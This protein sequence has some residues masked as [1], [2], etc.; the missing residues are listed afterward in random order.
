MSIA[1]EIT[2]IN[3]NIADAYTALGTKGATLPQSQNS[4]NLVSTI[5][6][7]TTL[8]QYIEGEVTN[9]TGYA[10][11]VAENALRNTSSLVSVNLPYAE[12]V[13]RFGFAYCR[14]LESVR[15]DSCT[16]LHTEA[17]YDC[18]KLSSVYAPELLTAGGTYS[19]GQSGNFTYC[20]ALKNVDFPKLQ[21]VGVY[22]FSYSGVENVNIPEVKEIYSYGFGNCQ[23][24]KHIVLPKVEILG[25]SAFK[26]CKNLRR[27]DF[28][29]I[30]T[31]ALD[32][33]S[34]CT[35]LTELIIRRRLTYP[36][37]GPGQSG[38]FTI[39]NNTIIYVEN[40]D[41]TW[42]Q[43]TSGWSTF[44]DAGRIKSV[45]ELPPLEE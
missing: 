6:T 44:Y 23:S 40:A 36:I 43:S 17:F 25:Y 8:D 4:A 29:A 12:R 28:H 21:M 38:T 27:I 39:P 42:Y 13:D 5:N 18:S 33:Y 3:Q 24:L 1:S 26:D 10:T 11:T 45:D 32:A 7:V 30:T 9:Y 41:L 16:Y 34:G 14:N 37:A 31:H 22:D 15:L 2:R 20:Y 19:A 35:S